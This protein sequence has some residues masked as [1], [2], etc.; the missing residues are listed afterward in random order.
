MLRNQ[1]RN[2]IE[3]KQVL[4]I[5]S[6]V[7][8]LGISPSSVYR[9]IK[10]ESLERVSKG[11]YVKSNL[12]N[13]EMNLLSKRTS[14]A[15]FSHE[16]ALLL[17]NLTDRE[18]SSLTVTVPSTYNASSLTKTG[19]RV[20]YIKPDFLGIGKTNIMSLEGNLVPS[21]DLERTIC[22]I[23]RSRSQ[24]DAQVVFGALKAYV[25]RR[26]KRLDILSDYAKKF[27][28][29]KLISQYLGVLL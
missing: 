20:F 19:V 29:S 11:V 18:P 28:V 26:D 25:K 15:V 2:Y 4:S 27:R 16:S 7:K 17:H 12:W 9:F 8:E 5:D 22:D 23:L 3:K 21:Y 6:A 13:D 24:I 1:L 14:V 10:D